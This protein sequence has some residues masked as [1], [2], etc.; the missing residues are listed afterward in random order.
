MAHCIPIP[1]SV[2]IFICLLRFNKTPFILASLLP[3]Q[4]LLSCLFC[5]PASYYATRTWPL[6]YHSAG[7][8]RAPLLSCSSPPTHLSL[9]TS[10]TQ[11]LNKCF[12]SLT[13]SELMRPDFSKAL[14][15]HAFPTIVL[16]GIEPKMHGNKPLP[17]V[18]YVSK[19][20]N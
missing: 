11:V 20:I 12:L 2:K 9:H 17:A 3:P 4:L 19:N 1:G 16:E 14:F 15:T 8:S 10:S 18:K 7:Y 13:G 6:C 5:L